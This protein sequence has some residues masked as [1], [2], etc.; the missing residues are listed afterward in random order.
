MIIED[1]GVRYYGML[2]GVVVDNVDPLG[3]HRVRIRIPGIVDDA[4]DWAL[5]AT[6]GG[7]GPQRGGHVVP[8]V[9]ADVWCWFER[10]DPN[11]VCGY[12]GGH[13]GERAAGSEA[14][15]D[16]KEADEP[17]KVQ[18]L[19]VGGVSITFDERDGQRAFRVVDR[20]SDAEIASLEIDR[21]G[22][23]VIIT[24]TSAL[25]LRATGLVQIDGLVVNINNRVV[26]T[27]PRPI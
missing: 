24:A 1:A 18:S 8:D 5:P 19:E 10:G 6:A 14:P 7:G 27:S 9:A 23:G 4:T 21:E 26:A 2:R 22:R 15:T 17:H 3:I 13:W 25:I 16:V 20:Q 12:M 11:G